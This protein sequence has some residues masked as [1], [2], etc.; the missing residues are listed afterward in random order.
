M[1]VALIRPHKAAPGTVDQYRTLSCT[2]QRAAAVADFYDTNLY[3][4]V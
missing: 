1:P 4:T 2:V 3:A